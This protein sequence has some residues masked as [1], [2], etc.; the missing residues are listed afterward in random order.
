MNF[1][2]S[3]TVLPK[4]ISKRNAN[5]LLLLLFVLKRLIEKKTV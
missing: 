4:L 3:M 5:K 2:Y 1:T